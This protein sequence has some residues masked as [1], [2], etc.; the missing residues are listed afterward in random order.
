[1]GMIKN[2][3]DLLDLETLESGVFPKWFDELSGLIEW[4]LDADSDGITV[5]L[6]ANVLCIFDI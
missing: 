1:M 3:W 4:Y 2:G 6:L 5:G